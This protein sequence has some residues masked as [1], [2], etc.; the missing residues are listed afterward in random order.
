MKTYNFRII[1]EQDEDGIFVAKCPSLRGCHTQAK[2][3]E[4]VVQ[5]MQEAIGVY[6]EVLKKR[7]QTKILEEVEQPKFFALQD[8]SV[9]L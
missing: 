4:K 9:S 8:L 6:L 7:Q 2:T 1:I 5:R 3:Y